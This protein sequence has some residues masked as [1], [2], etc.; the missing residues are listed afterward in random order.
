LAAGW[1]ARGGAYEQGLEAEAELRLFEARDLFLRA[2]REAP[3]APGVAEHTAWFLFLNGFHDEVCRDLLRQAAPTGQE[4]AAMERAAR[5]VERELGLRGPPDEAEAEAQ[6]A[7]HRQ[8]IDQAAGTT[9]AQLGGALVD[10]GDFA[11]GIPLMERALAAEPADGP[12]ALRLARAYSWAGRLADAEQA[13]ADLLE[14]YPG[15]PGVL[16]EAA[17]VALAGDKLE[18]ALAALVEAERAVPADPR[19]L[20]ARASVEQRLAAQAAAPP[21]ELPAP[22]ATPERDSFF[23]LGEQ[24][25]KEL[26]LYAARDLFRQSLRVDPEASGVAEHVAWFLFLNGFHDEECRDL[27][28]RAAPKAQEPAAVERAARQVEREL[29]L[30]GA[31]SSQERVDQRAFNQR[32]VDQA[33]AG[34]AEQAGR[35]RVDAG[36][37]AGGI[38]LLEEALATAPENAPLRLRLARAYFAAGR[39]REAE[40]AYRS[41]TEDYPQRPAL[42]LEYAQVVASL[43]RLERAR[44]LLIAA[45]RLRPGDDRILLER[46]RIEARLVNR[47]AALAAI[48]RMSNFH[49]AKPRAALAVGRA[50]HYR[51]QFGPARDAYASA[52]A[53]A[54]YLEEA[55]HGLVE[56]R[57]RRGE[58]GDGADLLDAWLPRERSL[59]WSPRTE[60]FEQLTDPRVRGQFATYSNSLGYFESDF[61]LDAAFH[62][63]PELMIRP[64]L[65]NS[66]VTQTGFTS[67]DRQ[68]AFIDVFSRPDE[69]YAT[70]VRLGVNGYTNDW[71]TPIGGISAEVF[72]VHWLDIGGGAEYFNLIDFQPPFGVGI[73]DIV[74]TIG[75]VG[76]KISSTQGTLFVRLR[77][78]TG[79][80]VY[81]RSRVAS[82][83]DGNVFHDDIV[84]V[85][86]EAAPGP[87]RTR[88]GWTYYYL[89]LME[90]APLFQQT[91][92]GPVTPAY[93]SPDALDVSTWNLEM[94]GRP[95]DQ[96]ELGW[97]GHLYHIL[98]NN[99]L[100][101]GVFL[102]TQFE[103]GSPMRIL[104]LDSRYFTQNR[105][106]TRQTNS[107]GSYD[108][109]NFVLNYEHRY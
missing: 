7:F 106:L 68:G 90:D 52:L 27:L 50:E 44:C 57:L 74:T 95:R 107:A 98:E 109:L 89:T 45:E 15:N 38:P 48:A 25:E 91:P 64:A 94:S 34:T 92:G 53:R 14:R 80:T 79:W 73:Y 103:L 88:A 102:Y 35:A 76:E 30:R 1:E 13:Y 101:V 19:I 105:G 61:G 20:R 12:L 36:D 63:T 6:Q 86:Y 83:S 51:G 49:R 67:I 32:M 72:P 8:M 70:N 85:A 65:V 104:R 93:Y 43:E 23:T 54:P 16:L 21:E 31:A 96:F 69:S 4:S 55:A 37:F 97:E 77:P 26:R 41:L 99:G 10:A 75:A 17:E 47:K 42:L 29:G 18:A 46:A 39:Q 40:Q 108:A 11:A 9:E 82:L 100:G 58:L 62:P 84:D 87:L 2:V 56:T 60:L 5:Q 59:D 78:W 22:Q 33:A 3:E 24:A 66:I 81:A 71:V 28:R